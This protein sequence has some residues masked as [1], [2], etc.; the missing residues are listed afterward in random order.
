[1]RQTRV[2]ERDT[3]QEFTPQTGNIHREAA[4]SE[5]PDEGHLHAKEP[6][7]LKAKS[8]RVCSSPAVAL[9]TGEMEMSRTSS[10][11]TKL[12]LLVGSLVFGVSLFAMPIMWRQNAKHLEA[13]AQKTTV[14]SEPT[15]DQ[16]KMSPSDRALTQEIRKAIHHDNS[17]SN[18]GQNIK[19][20]M[21]NGKVTLRGTVRSA[22]E[23]RNLEAKAA[24]AAGQENVSNQLEVATLK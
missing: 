14:Q 15:A 17:L 11:L 18:Y 10:K 8:A 3:D 1:L 7:V 6:I 12:L 19:I 24:S 9:F 2:E 16:R 22:E 4:E 20:F 23:K 13:D 21:Q 5:Q